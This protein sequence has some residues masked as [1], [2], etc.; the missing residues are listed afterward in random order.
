M[1]CSDYGSWTLCAA[2]YHTILTFSVQK[3]KSS[4]PWVEKQ[5][6]FGINSGTFSFQ[7]SW[8]WEAKEILS[9][10]L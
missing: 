5:N 10:L 8:K 2:M 6:Y 1:I 3:S 9:P 4:V 7:L